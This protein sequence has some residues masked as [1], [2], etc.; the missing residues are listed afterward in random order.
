MNIG[1]YFQRL[2]SLAHL[3]PAPQVSANLIQETSFYFKVKVFG[4]KIKE[5]ALAKHFIEVTV[6][7][8]FT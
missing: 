8:S 7:H 2:Y 5:A 6:R 3:P 4:R 1:K